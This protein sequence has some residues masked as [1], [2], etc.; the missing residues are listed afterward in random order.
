MNA[1]SLIRRA[2]ARD[3]NAIARLA[4]TLGYR[5][6]S[7][8]VHR[9]LSAILAS[10]ADLMIVAENSAGVIVGWLQA[11]ACHIVESGFRVEI[12]GLVVAVET[13]RSG[14]GRALVA[15]AE[16]WARSISAEAVVVRSNVQRL[17]SHAFYP[18]LGYTQTK[19]QAVYRKEI[20]S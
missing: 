15:E 5:A 12:M 18:A 20:S 14:V 6:A 11:H 2:T 8:A 17:E 19:T 9:R 7:D 13:R 10:D 4:E 16:R 1:A 3:A